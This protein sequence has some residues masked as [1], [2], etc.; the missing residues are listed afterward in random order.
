M[1]W[2]GGFKKE[3]NNNQCS[4]KVMETIIED[5]AFID[6]RTERDLIKYPNKNLPI[7]KTKKLNTNV[8][9]DHLEL[10]KYADLIKQESDYPKKNN[11]GE[12]IKK[13]LR[14]ELEDLCPFGWDT[15]RKLAPPNPKKFGL[16]LKRSRRDSET[17]KT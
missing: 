6:D 3:K 8:V 13:K 16:V 11:R 14:A 7:A 12:K 15:R 4:R 2:S 5:D 17:K 10:I 1:G 9:D